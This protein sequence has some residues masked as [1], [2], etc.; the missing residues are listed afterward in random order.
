M[1]FYWTMSMTTM[2]NAEDY[3]QQ[4]KVEETGRNRQSTD[5][6][7]TRKS[8]VNRIS[9]LSIRTPRYCANTYQ[10]GLIERVKI[11]NSSTFLNTSVNVLCSFKRDLHSPTH[12]CSQ[13]GPVLMSFCPGKQEDW[14]WRTLPSQSVVPLRQ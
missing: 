7:W 11:L 3:F 13:Q 10:Y 8:A 1:V 2:K 14:Q 5:R 4:N 12:L 6:T 9:W